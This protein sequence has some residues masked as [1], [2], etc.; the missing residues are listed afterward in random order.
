MPNSSLGLELF[1]FQELVQAAFTADTSGFE[2]IGDLQ[3]NSV[4]DLPAIMH[5]ESVTG[6]RGNEL[7]VYDVTVTLSA[8][9]LSGDD[10]W[11]AANAAY[12]AMMGWRQTRLIPGLGGLRW[13]SNISMFSSVQGQSKMMLG[14]PVEQFTGLFILKAF[15]L[16]YFD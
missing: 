16:P 4:D 1:P 2:I 5:F 15:E 13:E 11:A 3:E 10:A 9:G 14:K 12:K 6:T 7:G 8:L